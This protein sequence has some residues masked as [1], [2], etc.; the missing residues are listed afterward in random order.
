MSEYKEISLAILKRYSKA[1][2]YNIYVNRASDVYTKVFNEGDSID[3]DRVEVYKSKGLKYF[4]AT[5][6]DYEIYSMMIEKLGDILVG[7]AKKLSGPESLEILK[8]LALFTMDEMVNKNKFDERVIESATNIVTSSL[9]I[10][11]QSEKGF[12]KI[13]SLMSRHPHT[14]KHSM[15]VSIFS[16][17]LGQK[18]GLNRDDVL[19]M[20][21]LGAFLHDVGTSQLTFDPE[22]KETLTAEERKEVWR[23]PELGKQ[24]LDGIRTIRTEVLLIVLQHHEQINGRGYP[25]SLKGG[26]IYIL[27]K[28]VAIADVFSSLITKRSFREAY[29]TQVALNTMQQD[30]GKFDRKFLKA[31][32]SLF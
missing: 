7:H 18:V 25:N 19:E 16:V 22:D 13:L 6:K 23:H 32:T 15:M 5:S 20:L 31:F 21:G 14:V 4:Y 30:E 1:L 3:W 29:P 2:K 26:E 27:S 8:E 17:M 11:A 9:T 10:L 28:V 24:S 12:L